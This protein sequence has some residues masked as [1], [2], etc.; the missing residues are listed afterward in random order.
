MSYYSIDEIET[1]GIKV[2]AK[3]LVEARDLGFLMPS[4]SRNETPDP[5][6]HAGAEVVLPLWLATPLAAESLSENSDEP[7]L[8]LVEPK[9]LHSDV[10]NVLKSEPLTLD[11][12]DQD[13]LFTYLALR[14]SEMFTSNELTEILQKTVRTRAAYIFDMALAQ[15]GNDQK[16]DEYE[17]HLY[18][19]ASATER[20]I[21]QWKQNN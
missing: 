17:Q 14:W 6:I 16:L 20:D 11:L 5:N 3:F 1:D 12:R 2:P 8:E 10:L 18:S 21:R 15:Q 9:A 4:G 19:I 7:I 13:R